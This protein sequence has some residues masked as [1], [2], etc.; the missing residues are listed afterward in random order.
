M[1]DPEPPKREPAVSVKK[2]LNDEYL[3]SM[4]DGK[5]Y[6]T[7]KRHLGKHGMTPEKYRAEFG[8][9]ASYPMV[10]P[11]YSVA[12]SKLAKELGL[13]NQSEGRKPAKLPKASGKRGRP[14]KDA[15]GAF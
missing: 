14:R 8:L 13:G 3:I 4:L 9:P 11:S 6:R 1:A 10:A 7:L 2:S 12:R 15:A 5:Q